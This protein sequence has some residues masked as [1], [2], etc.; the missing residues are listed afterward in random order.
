[1][2]TYYVGD[3]SSTITTTSLGTGGYVSTYYVAVTAATAAIA[4][5]LALKKRRGS[6]EVFIG[7]VY[8]PGQ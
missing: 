5:F 1:V 2:S 6:V 7:E 8:V 3:L 4:M